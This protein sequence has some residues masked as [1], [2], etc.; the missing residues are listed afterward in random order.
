MKRL[1]DAD[2]ELFKYET[3]K[4]YQA[5][6]TICGE[7]DFRQPIV[8]S[9]RNKEIID[10]NHPGSYNHSLEYGSKGRKN[11]YICPK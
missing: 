8:I 2:P 9:K 6:S 1:Y 4:K 5:Y 7:V 10:K 11:I 3:N